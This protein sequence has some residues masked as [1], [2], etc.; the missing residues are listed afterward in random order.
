MRMAPLIRTLNLNCLS[1]VNN[2]EVWFYMY[3]VLSNI[4]GYLYGLHDAD[5]AV[6][7]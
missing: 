4:L 5:H 2:R 1:R 3:V 7:S 6:A